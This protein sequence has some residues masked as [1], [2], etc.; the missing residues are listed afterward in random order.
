MVVLASLSYGL[1]S[2][3]LKRTLPDVDPVGVVTGTMAISAL[4]TLPLMLTDMPSSGDFELDSIVSLA[5]LGVA[6][7][8]VVFVI[9]F[10]LIASEGPVPSS[11]VAYVAPAFSVVYGVTILGEFSRSRRQPGC[12]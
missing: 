12:C 7:T 4:L 2:W 11:L 1:G 3:T 9:F 6:C 8:G 10:H 5:V